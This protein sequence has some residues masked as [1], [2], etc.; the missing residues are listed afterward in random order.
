MNM[1]A[2]VYCCTGSIRHVVSS[3]RSKLYTFYI[4]LLVLTCRIFLSDIYLG[5][6]SVVGVATGYVLGRSGDRFPMSAG[7][8]APVQTDSGAYPASYSMGTGSLSRG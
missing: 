4:H 7:V 6:D 3:D 8:F 2:V 5:Q 1:S